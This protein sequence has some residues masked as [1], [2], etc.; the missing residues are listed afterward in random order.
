MGCFKTNGTS[1]EVSSMQGSAQGFVRRIASSLPKIGLF[2]LIV[3]LFANTANAQVSTA[4]VNGVVRDSQGAVVPGATI[5]LKSVDTQVEHPSVSNNAGAYVI[6]NITPGKYTIQA[7]AKGFNPQRTAEF[8]L[9]V[10]QTATLDFTLAVGTDTQVVTVDATA[11]QLDVS[12]ASLGTVIEAKQVNELPLDGRNF[13]ALL[14]LTPG[15]V[16][17]MTGQSNGMSGNGGFGAAVA[18]GSNYSFPS[19]KGQTNRSDFFLMDGPYKY[20]P[21]KST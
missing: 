18:I 19:I 3:F 15:V 6:L 5:V 4:S 17:I 21:L 14:Q 16:P 8:V 12:G 7:T 10:D 20:S 2:S 13:T 1:R 11:A 9:A